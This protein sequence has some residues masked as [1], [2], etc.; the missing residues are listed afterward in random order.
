MAHPLTAL[1]RRLTAQYDPAAW[2]VLLVKA[3][4]AHARELPDVILRTPDHWL[5]AAWRPTQQA[6][7]RLPE[8]VVIGSPAADNALAELVLRLPGGA[9]LWLAHPDAVDAALAAE[10]LLGA[11]RNLEAYQRRALVHFVAAERARMAA[12]LA[13]AYTDHDAGFARFRRQLHEE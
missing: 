13:R 5:A 11:D 4:P 12:R 1:H 8:A 9:P 6:L 2:P 10:A 7:E 3:V